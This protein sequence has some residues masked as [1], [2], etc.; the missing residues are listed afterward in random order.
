MYVKAECMYVNEM[1]VGECQN[2]LWLE[3]PLIVYIY[4]YI[5]SIYTVYIYI[6]IYILKG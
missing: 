1:Y 6:Y 4:T 3:R 5:Y 2:E